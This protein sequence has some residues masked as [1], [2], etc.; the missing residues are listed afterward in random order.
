MSGN[1]RVY[2]IGV[3]H[4]VVG[5]SAVVEIEPRAG[6]LSGF[7]EI[8]SLGTSGAVALVNGANANYGDSGVASG[9]NLRANDRIEFEGPAKFYLAAQLNSVT[10]SYVQ[11]LSSG[12]TLG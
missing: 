7:L 9:H 6:V 4:I 5:N 10:V 8:H 12:A 3:S 1:E 11:R 2:N